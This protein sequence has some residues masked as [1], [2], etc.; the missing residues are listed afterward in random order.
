MKQ[1]IEQ[2]IE[3]YTKQFENLKWHKETNGRY[4]TAEELTM[5]NWRIND[6]FETIQDLKQVLKVNS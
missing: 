3:E 1:Q 5:L 2:L 6:K 4:L